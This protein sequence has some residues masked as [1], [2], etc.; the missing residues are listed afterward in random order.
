MKMID[1]LVIL[2]Y[3]IIQIHQKSNKTKIINTHIF[4][5]IE[6][7]HGYSKKENILL[8]ILLYLVN[9]HPAMIRPFS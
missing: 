3:I 1:D 6:L 8:F 4:Y 7:Q 2:L 9:S 5:S